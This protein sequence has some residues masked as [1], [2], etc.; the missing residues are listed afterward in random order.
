MVMKHEIEG[1]EIMECPSLRICPFF[2]NKMKDMPAAAELLKKRYCLGDNSQCAR[3]MVASK[4]G[5]ERV[6]AD[7]FPGQTDRAREIL[8][9]ANLL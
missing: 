9:G 7:L 8:K 1:G 6:P 5:K 2:N 3:F 4:L